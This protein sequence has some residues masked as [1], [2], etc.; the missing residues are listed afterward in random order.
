[1]FGGHFCGKRY[2]KE[3]APNDHSTKYAIFYEQKKISHFDLISSAD[4]LSISYLNFPEKLWINS[5][6][7]I[8]SGK[9]NHKR[10][11][12]NSFKCYDHNRA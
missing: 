10:N 12:V 6:M 4:Y 7:T 1:M 11:I 2:L 5:K 9:T 3:L 8:K